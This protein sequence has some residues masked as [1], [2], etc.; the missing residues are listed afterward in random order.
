MISQKFESAE[1]P[2]GS[3]QQTVCFREAIDFF[4]V[5]WFRLPAEGRQVCIPECV[6]FSAN[7]YPDGRPV[8]GDGIGRAGRPADLGQFLTFTFPGRRPLAPG[9]I[10]CHA[11]MLSV[12][13]EKGNKCFYVIGLDLGTS[14]VKAVGFDRTGHVLCRQSV[15][16]RMLSPAPGRQELRAEVV[17]RAVLSVVRR[18][19]ACLACP[20]AAIALSSAMHSVLAVDE[21]GRPLTPLLVWADTRAADMAE[22]LRGTGFA[23]EVHHRCGTPWHAMLPLLKIPWIRE[24]LADIMPAV[25]RFLDIKSYVVQR[26]CG[27]PLLDTSL[28]SATGLFDGFTGD[29]FGPSLDF[30]GISAAALPE[31]VSTRAALPP[32]LPGPARSMGIPRDI[33]FLIG[34]ADGCLSNLGAGAGPECRRAVLTVGTSAALR[35]STRTMDIRPSPALFRYG[36][37]TDWFVIGGGSN[38]GGAVYDWFTRTFLGRTPGHAAVGA[39]QE[40]LADL[41]PGSAGLTFLPYLLGERAPVWD[42]GAK[43]CFHGIGIRHT[44]D[45]FHRAVL[46]GLCFNLRLVGDSLERAGHGFDHILADGGFTNHP[47]WLQLVADVFGKPVQRASV[48]DSAARGAGILAMQYLGLQTE[49]WHSGGMPIPS[50]IFRPDLSLQ[51]TYRACIDAFAG[52]YGRLRPP[53]EAQNP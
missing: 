50:P 20:P 18:C 1:C 30:A 51:D 29:W 9:F 16:L 44:R 35:V 41:P 53:V 13:M 7:G 27:V 22:P 52:L 6:C 11:H 23:R 26:L 5:V 43:G 39:A 37:F 25:H 12:S 46:E 4:G 8:A 14:S 33:P 49:D 10:Q 31:L 42:A 2:A 15:P 38:S 28:A 21:A 34:A 45:H 3:V 17:Y 36:L 47:A 48:A 32:L 24:H 19:V 40:R